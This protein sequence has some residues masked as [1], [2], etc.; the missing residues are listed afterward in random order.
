M[1][2]NHL[3]LEILERILD[4]ISEEVFCVNDR[5][6][7]V[8]CNKNASANLFNNAN[9]IGQSTFVAFPHMTIE[10]STF[11]KVFST[12]K[13]IIKKPTTFFCNDG[14]RK[15]TITTTLPIKSGD[16]VV[17]AYEISEDITGI[18]NLTEQW[19][20]DNV[21]LRKDHWEGKDQKSQGKYYTI[22][23]IIGQ[24]DTIRS[25]KEQILILAGSTSNLLIYGET[26]TG[27]EMVAQS[28]FCL[29]RD[30][31]KAPF[32]A[33]NCAAIPE[34]LL[35]SML[36]GTVKGAFTGAETRPGLFELANKGVLYLDE[37]N[38]MSLALQAKILRVLQE[39][40]VRRVGASE[41]VPVDFRLIA[42]TNVPPDRLLSRGIMREDLF[43][44][45]NVL[46]IEIPPLRERKEDIPFL[47][48]AITREFNQKLHKQII[49][50]D[51]QSIDLLMK[52]HWPGNVRE[53]R[54]IVE[55]AMSLTTTKIINL[56]QIKVTP[57][58]M[59]PAPGPAGA[60]PAHPGNDRIRL[61]EALRE[62]EIKIIK[63]ELQKF[64]GNIA[65][66][67][68]E[69]D[70]PQ[71]TLNNKVDKY[72]LRPFIAAL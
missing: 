49:G 19:V 69:L 6:E 26:G 60:A 1:M 57:Q 10:E 64:N 17:G 27:K 43:Y 56:K 36:F 22:D 62:T 71:Q 47:I 50:F 48:N 72:G 61:K 16:K 15:I 31:K 28:I 32:I 46:Y 7:I 40:R 8:Y 39:G 23:S 70:L 41:E 65:R 44:R 54:N 53:F 11:A 3:S 4:D 63:A 25:L 67:A 5:Y 45:I 30:P 42:S 24:S 20:I 13:P 14:R 52:H 29:S 12:G 37:I 58:G 38:S 9:V 66:T 35:E 2:D 21:Q 34:T 59:Q 33:Q 55:R 18:S 68:R 51:D